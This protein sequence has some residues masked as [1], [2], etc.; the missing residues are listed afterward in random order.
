MIMDIEDFDGELA[1][2]RILSEQN[3]TEADLLR[4]AKKDKT[5][6]DANEA[7]FI[8]QGRCP[9]CFEAPND[10]GTVKHHVSCPVFFKD[11][12]AELKAISD[13]MPKRPDDYPTESIQ[14]KLIDEY[15]DRNKESDSKFNIRTN[16]SIRIG[17][18]KTGGPDGVG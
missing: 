16:Y 12:E 18:D 1:L 9:D 6:L 10:N 2:D 13:R 15:G 7:W 11:L 5:M 17:D 3:P 4:Q 8:L 14:K